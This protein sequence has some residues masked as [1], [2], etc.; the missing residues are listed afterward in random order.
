MP[1]CGEGQI[2]VRVRAVSI[3]PALRGWM[4][5]GTTYIKGVE[6]GAVMRAFAAGEVVE[7][8]N[9]AFAVGMFVAG[10]LGV[11][12]YALS[13]GTGLETI[14]AASVDE[15]PRFLSALGMPGM[16]AY[17]GLLDK[18]Q[19]MRG[20]TV[21]VSAAAGAVGAVVGQIAKIHGCRAIGIAGGTDKC[22]YVTEEL[23]FDAAIDYKTEN[24]L[25]RLKILA[26]NGVDVYFDNV[27][28]EMLDA[29]LAHLARGARVVI[30]GAMSQY[31]NAGDDGKPAPPQ[32]PKNYMKIVTARGVMNGII[33]LD[34]FD[35]A[36]EFRSQMQAWIAEG[37]LHP[38]EH[39]IEGIER[40]P[41]ALLM[42]FRGENFG[43]LVLSI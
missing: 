28:G 24:V 37:K 14:P 13:D 40:F 11:Q 17:W 43:K 23:G 5:E 27:G 12:E 36:N 30:C 3:D 20:E 25:E 35:R 34:Y 32:G 38:K 41:D 10:M 39:V 18:G 16:T 8:R 21:L 33:V 4:N 29:A 19:P 22:R 26:P 6:I 1:V 7:S 42:L 9:E 15:L 2:L 31:N